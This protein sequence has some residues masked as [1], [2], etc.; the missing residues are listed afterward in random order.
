MDH[1]A[2]AVPVLGAG[3]THTHLALDIAGPAGFHSAVG[4]AGGV[5][6][7][8]IDH[9]EIVTADAD[10]AERFYT[11]IL[12]FKL[13]ARDHIE[14]SSL[15]VPMDLAYLELGGTT[16]ELIAYQNAEVAPAPA[17]EHVGYRMIAL[18]VEDMDKAAVYLRGKGVEL[19]WGPRVAP[20]YARAEICDPEGNHIE[21]RQWFK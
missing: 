7:K 6:F 9:V 12:G 4:H 1:A 11:E 18:E 13:K 20:T 3:A 10:R 2:A 19:V 16:V 5:M 21:L 17:E 14:R 8:R 15:G